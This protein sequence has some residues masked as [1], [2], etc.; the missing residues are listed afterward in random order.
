MVR[1]FPGLVEA[2]LLL[3]RTRFLAGELDAAARGAKAALDLQPSKAEALLLQAQVHLAKG[4]AK[5]AADFLEQAVSASFA[6]R[7]TPGFCRCKAQALLA[8]GENTAAVKRAQPLPPAHP[9][10]PSSCDLA[11]R[12]IALL[13]AATEC[14]FPFSSAAAVLEGALSQIKAAGAA[15]RFSPADKAGVIIDLAEAYGA[16]LPCLSPS[17]IM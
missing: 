9:S 3:A 8:A 5:A 6:I 4:S 1:R 2:Q 17:P 11:E 13:S 16:N 14:F 15:S 12:A 7:E 10:D